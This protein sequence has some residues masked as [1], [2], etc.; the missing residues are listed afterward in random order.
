[1]GDERLRQQ[2]LEGAAAGAPDPVQVGIKTYDDTD[3]VYD[4]RNW[5]LF[6][7]AQAFSTASLFHQN[8][9]ISPGMTAADDGVFTLKINRTNDNLA[10]RL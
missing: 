4:S 1:M 3:G 2:L 8:V 9:G 10:G 5:A 7:F 6:G